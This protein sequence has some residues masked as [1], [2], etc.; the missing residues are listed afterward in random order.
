VK[1]TLNRK[2]KIFKW[3]SRAHKNASSSSSEEAIPLSPSDMW[4]LR[5]RHRVLR[6]WHAPTRKL[7][8][9]SSS[10]C[11]LRRTSSLGKHFTLSNPPS[12]AYSSAHSTSSTYSS[13][14]ASSARQ[15][16]SSV[17]SSIAFP[18]VNSC[19]DMGRGIRRMIDVCHDEDLSYR[20]RRFHGDCTS[21]KNDPP[22]RQDV[23]DTL[24]TLFPL[25]TS[26][27]ERRMLCQG[28]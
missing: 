28:G 22:S 7:R 13:S 15:F 18:D 9:G 26:D 10:G 20:I 16:S 3:G 17:S 2:P 12:F 6:V 25:C 14:A 27:W 1:S 11:L 8:V 21:K 19:E 23:M 24:S 4:S 5:L